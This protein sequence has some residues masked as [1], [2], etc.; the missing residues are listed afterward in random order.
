MAKVLLETARLRLEE[1]EDGDAPFVVALLNTDGF[2]QNIGDRGVRTEADARRY[3]AEGPR[4][5]YAAHGFGLWKVS[6]RE[7][8][9]AVGLC[10]LLRRDTLPHADLGYAFLPAFEGRGYATEAGAHVLDFAFGTRGLDTVLA[11][12]N[13]DNAG[14]IRVLEKLGFASQGVQP[15]GDKTLL[16]MSASAR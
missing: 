6:R 13:P 12:V 9:V 11:I 4:A 5:S 2:L 1:L 7:D 15:V 14:S 16:V 8:G 10:G 3:L